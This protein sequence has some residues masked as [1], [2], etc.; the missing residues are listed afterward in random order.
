MFSES[1]RTKNYVV[2]LTPEEYQAV[3]KAAA[4]KG[5]TLATYFRQAVYSQ[6]KQDIPELVPNPQ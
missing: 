4:L 3:K 5:V 1:N 6:V 2:R